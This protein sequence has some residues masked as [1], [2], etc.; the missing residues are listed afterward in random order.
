VLSGLPMVIEIHRAL[1]WPRWAEPPSAA[2]LFERAVPAPSD[3]LLVLLPPAEHAVV[4][5][6][7]GWAHRPLRRILDLLD[8]A[9]LT[10]ADEEC[11]AAAVARDWNLGRLWR[12]TIAAASGLFDDGPT[13]WPLRTWARDL[14]R[15]R[16]RTVAETA[17]ARWLAPAACL[18]PGAA[19]RAGLGALQHDL[20]PAPG[21]SWPDKL[22][23]T[24]AAA[25]RARRTSPAPEQSPWEA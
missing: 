23:A 10:A 12:T 17:L 7:H 20:R 4:V 18:P 2:E 1:K 25:R 13:S 16:E 11:R 22:R 3:A 14:P 9:V 19:L 6:A 8:V 24:R 5:A 21:Q 15:A